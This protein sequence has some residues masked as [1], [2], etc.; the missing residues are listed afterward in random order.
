MASKAGVKSYRV[1]FDFYVT[2]GV[3]LL[4]IANFSVFI[5]EAIV[6]SYV[7]AAHSGYGW[8]LKWFGLVPAGVF[9]GL[10]IWKPF[11]YL[12][13]H[14]VTDILHI[15][16]NMLTLWMFGRELELVWGRD[17]FLRYYFMTGVVRDSSTSSSTIFPIS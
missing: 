16:L 8:I 12:F 4:L 7:G 1:S 15:L 6:Y 3:K 2:P 17:R 14:D 9:P 11:T 5:L 10:R 13:L